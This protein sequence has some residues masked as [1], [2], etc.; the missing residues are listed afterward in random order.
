MLVGH[1]HLRSWVGCGETRKLSKLPPIVLGLPLIPLSDAG[2]VAMTHTGSFN[3]PQV[4][5]RQLSGVIG[6][7]SRVD[8]R[9]ERL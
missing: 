7:S 5:L 6:D 9:R 8:R 4:Q 3:W 2:Y 1:D